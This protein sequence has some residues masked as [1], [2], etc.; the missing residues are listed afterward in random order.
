MANHHCSLLIETVCLPHMLQYMMTNPPNLSIPLHLK[1][2]GGVMN[3]QHEAMTH[4]KRNGVGK[5]VNVRGQINVCLPL[6]LPVSDAAPLQ[7]RPAYVGFVQLLD[8]LL[9]P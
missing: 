3:K 7:G 6:Q 1:N 9:V 4:W 5:K 2:T 8:L